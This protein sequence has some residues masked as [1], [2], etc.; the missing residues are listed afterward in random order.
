MGL[1]WWFLTSV[2]GLNYYPVGLFLIDPIGW[3]FRP[4]A[5]VL[6]IITMIGAVVMLVWGTWLFVR[7]VVRAAA[8]G[9]GA[10]VFFGTWAAIIAA[11]WIMGVLRTP[12]RF[13]GWELDLGSQWAIADIASVSAASVEWAVRWGWFTAV[14]AALMHVSST[15]ASTVQPGQHGSYGPPAPA[16]GAVPPGTA[17]VPPGAAPYHRGPVPLGDSPVPPDGATDSAYRSPQP[18]AG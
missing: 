13:V 2:V 1:A 10:A 9:R 17:P 11:T 7:L 12:T 18:P 5:R 8:P 14:V 15:S 4:G 6:D 3:A 16:P